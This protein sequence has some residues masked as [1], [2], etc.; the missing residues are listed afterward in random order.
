[1]AVEDMAAA[2]KNN[3]VNLSLIGYLTGDTAAAYHKRQ[4]THKDQKDHEPDISAEMV[5]TID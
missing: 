1:M 3:F 4:S 2:P 5:K